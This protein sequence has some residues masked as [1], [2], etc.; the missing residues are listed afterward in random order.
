MNEHEDAMTLQNSLLRAYEVHVK[1]FNTPYTEALIAL[2]MFF[3]TIIK[4]ISR[5]HRHVLTEEEA[6]TLLRKAFK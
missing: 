2:V 5:R 3:K 4:D 1:A 6:V